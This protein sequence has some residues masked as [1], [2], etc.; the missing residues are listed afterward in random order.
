METDFDCAQSDCH[1]E[2]S[3]RV[4]NVKQFLFLT[5]LYEMDF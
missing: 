5:S 4:L 2:R 1:P 3:R